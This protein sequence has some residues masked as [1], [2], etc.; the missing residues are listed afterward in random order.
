[1][2]YS[3]LENDKIIANKSTKGFHAPRNFNICGNTNMPRNRKI[4]AFM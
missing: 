1:M 2:P 3:N 4:N